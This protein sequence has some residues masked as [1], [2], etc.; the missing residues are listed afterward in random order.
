V[1]IELLIDDGRHAI[2]IEIPAEES[3]HSRG[4]VSR[5]RQHLRVLHIQ[6]VER[7]ASAEKRFHLFQVLF[8]KRA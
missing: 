3:A 6:H 1:P 8:I 2:D 4:F 7:R 5:H